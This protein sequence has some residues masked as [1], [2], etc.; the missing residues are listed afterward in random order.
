MAHQDFANCRDPELV[1][2]LAEG[3]L[4]PEAR[5]QALRLLEQSEPCRDLFRQ[6]TYGKYPSIPNYTIVEQVGKGGFGVVYKAVHHA[7]E[8]AEALKVLFSKTP[9]LTTYFENEVHLIARLRHP[10]IAML[11]EAQLST[12]PLYYTME[13]VEGERL[14]EYLKSREVSLAQRIEIIRKVAL[15][16]S[17]AHEQGVVHRDVKPQN[18]LIDA[19]GEPHIV[20]F[21]IA[22]RLE[23]LTAPELERAPQEESTEGPVGTV[24][25]IAP[26]QVKG[27]DVDARADI[28][29][30]GALLFH[31]VTGE[32]ARFARDGRR[33]LQILRSRRIG[34]AEDLAAIIARCVEDN[35]ALR[36]KSGAALAA[37]LQNYLDGRETQARR[38]PST[39]LKVARIL[40]LIIRNKP[41]QLRSTLLV[42]SALCVAGIF[43][44]FGARLQSTST[45]APQTALVGFTQTTED[46]IQEKR[47]GGDIPGLSFYEPRSY[48]LLHGKLLERLALAKPRVVVF[49]YYFIQP[50]P[51]YDAAFT[52]SIRSVQE[53]GIPVVMAVRAFDINGEPEVIE[54]LRHIVHGFG[55]AANANPNMLSTEFEVLAAVK[56]GFEEPL[57]SLSVAAYAAARFP[58][59]FPKL[60]L[61]GDQELALRYLKRKPDPGRSRFHSEEDRIPLQAHYRMTG[62]DR[63]FQLNPPHILKDDV[64]YAFRIGIDVRSRIPS[65]RYE[66]VFTASEDQLQTWFKGKGVVIGQ[67][68]GRADLWSMRSGQEIWGYE[69]QAAALDSLLAGERRVTLDFRTLLQWT[70]AWAV[71]VGIVVTLVPAPRVRELKVS[72]VICLTAVLLGFVLAVNVAMWR[73]EPLV[74]RP[75][76]ALSTL[77]VGGGLAFLAKVIRERQLQLTPQ[78]ITYSPK[79]GDLP[80][81]IV[82]R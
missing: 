32:P 33:C 66:D 24:G 81:T 46:A 80:S 38:L 17:Y 2:G 7:K 52:Q 6:L 69:V 67:A 68:L 37:D 45:Q 22:K 4:G 34:L 65:V 71:A 73:P 5:R 15:A 78:A 14:N 55:S 62:Q 25:Y 42:A 77:L 8:R 30:A 12:P 11:Y 3:K 56:R 54:P 72:V 48:R 40:A 13:F 60:R 28:F 44:A 16:L 26:E 63:V 57:P 74:L 50:A 43:S 64:N 9:L 82:A 59:S 39:F 41:F 36:Y 29:A 51:E 70:V 27:G 31:C 47:L 58:D 23:L 21:G 18:I 49:D 35:P 76:L 1:H 10:N 75:G 53:Q 61:E 19:A 79:E 20:D